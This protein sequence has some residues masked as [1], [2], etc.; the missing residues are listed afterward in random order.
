[1][2]PPGNAK[3]MYDTSCIQYNFDCNDK[4]KRRFG[5]NSISLRLAAVRNGRIVG[6]VG[7]KLEH[8]GAQCRTLVLTLDIAR[9][10]AD[11]RPRI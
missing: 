4:I 11:A 10:D 5:R 1:M 7:D 2:T 6:A 8:G 3:I 9:G